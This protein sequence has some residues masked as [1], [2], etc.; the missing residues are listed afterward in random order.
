MFNASPDV[1]HSDKE[2]GQI[3]RCWIPKYLEGA[4]DDTCP[5]CMKN[6]RPEGELALALSCGHYFHPVCIW[7]Y[8]FSKS[9]C[10]LRASG[11]DDIVPTVTGLLNIDIAKTC[12]MC[13]ASPGS[14]DISTTNAATKDILLPGEDEEAGKGY[15]GG[16]GGIGSGEGGAASSTTP[17]GSMAMPRSR[18]RF[19]QEGL[20]K[21]AESM[22]GVGEVRPDVSGDRH[23]LQLHANL[24]VLFLR[25]THSEIGTIMSRRSR[26]SCRK[27]H[28]SRCGMRKFCASCMP[29]CKIHPWEQSSSL[30]PFWRDREGTGDIFCDKCFWIQ[31]LFLGHLG[32]CDRYERLEENFF[33]RPRL[34]NGGGLSGRWKCLDTDGCWFLDSDDGSSREESECEKCR[35]MFANSWIC[36]VEPW[37][38]ECAP[39]PKKS[40]PQEQPLPVVD[41]VPPEPDTPIVLGVNLPTWSA[42]PGFLAP[43]I[44]PAVP[45]SVPSTDTTSSSSTEVSGDV[46]NSKPAAE[47]KPG[48]PKLEPNPKRKPKKR[49]PDR[50]MLQTEIAGQN[51]DGSSEV[52]SVNGSTDGV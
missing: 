37:C 3:P 6:F 45:A 2:Y 1:D 20:A 9:D 4:T 47:T 43:R 32:P 19:S 11:R 17:P 36:Y 29:R 13:R 23:T 35:K 21:M 18:P 7:K 40:A 8:L 51:G 50:E 48:G 26:R 22:A 25:N 49:K 12:P 39:A 14:K 16:S 24:F 31:I 46:P 15:V 5:I 52:G 33:L 10:N 44:I 41:P 34:F 30:G 27:K 38:S 42:S 28:V